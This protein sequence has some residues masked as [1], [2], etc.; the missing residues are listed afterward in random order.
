MYFYIMATF[1]LEKDLDFY[2]RE[3]HG[4]IQADIRKPLC[5][6]RRLHAQRA[7]IR[8]QDCHDLPRQVQNV[9][10]FAAKNGLLYEV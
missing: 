9:E 7:P 4:D 1:V 3:I 10:L 8:R 6:D 5:M 2:L